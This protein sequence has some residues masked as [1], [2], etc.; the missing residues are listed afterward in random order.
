MKKAIAIAQL[1]T[2]ASASAQAV[3]RQRQKLGFQALLARQLYQAATNIDFLKIQCRSLFAANAPVWTVIGGAKQSTLPAT[4]C[5]VLSWLIV[6]VKPGSAQLLPA[7]DSTSQA[8]ALVAS[9]GCSREK[10]CR[11]FV[12]YRRPVRTNCGLFRPQARISVKLVA[13]Q[14]NP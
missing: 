13:T 4:W 2:A 6:M 8:A 3:K 5:R 7:F 11:K 1:C 14:G 10:I 9:E 12:A